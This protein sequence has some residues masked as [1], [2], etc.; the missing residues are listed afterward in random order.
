MLCFKSHV[1]AADVITCK[2]YNVNLE[3][4]R[5]ECVLYLCGCE[6]MKNKSY[7]ASLRCRANILVLH[8]ID[9]Y[10]DKEKVEE[11]EKRGKKKK[12][13]KKNMI[14]FL[15]NILLIHYCH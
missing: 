12:E 15:L 1:H 9:L 2:V 10:V 13:K 11:E 4:M 3:N 7:G 8:K 14:F 6:I 5:T